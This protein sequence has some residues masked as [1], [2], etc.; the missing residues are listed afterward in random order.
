MIDQ[1]VGVRSLLP[2]LTLPRLDGGHL[3]F[4]DLRGTKLVLYMWGSW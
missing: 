1:T 3:R 2:A 4:A